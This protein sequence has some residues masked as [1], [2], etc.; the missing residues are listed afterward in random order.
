MVCHGS[1]SAC[2]LFLSRNNPDPPQP[3]WCVVRRMLPLSGFCFCHGTIPTIPNPYWAMTLVKS[4][5]TR[6]K[7]H[8]RKAE[9]MKFKN[10]CA[11]L[12]MVE[13]T[14][15]DMDEF[16]LVDGGS[17]ASSCGDMDEGSRAA[18]HCDAWFVE[19][20]EAWSGACAH[21][22]MREGHCPLAGQRHAGY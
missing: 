4:Q 3:L 16:D 11:Q 18:C 12:G 6:N 14:Q 10:K 5:A 13:A 9:R 8:A 21:C 22:A 15:S 2:F 7:A 19:T 1:H 20:T 17:P